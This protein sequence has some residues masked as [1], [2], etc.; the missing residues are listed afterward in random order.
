MQAIIFTDVNGS[1]GLGRAAGAY[2]IASEFRKR[3]Q[4]VKVIDFFTSFKLE[5]IKQLILRHKTKETEWIGFSSTFIAP[6]G[7]DAFA[8]RVK[9]RSALEQATSIGLT[10]E[11]SKDLFDF[12]KSLGLQT[13]V[14]GM[15][16]KHEF[17]GVKYL[18]GPAEDHF[19]K[20]FNF[21]TSQI[22]WDHDDHIFEREHLP[23]EIARG[24]IF[25]CSFCS[26][27]LNGK[28]LW[29]FCKSPKVL[30]EEMMRNYIDHGTEG[31]MF[32]DD[33]YNDSVEKI[34]KLNDMYKTLPFNLEFSSY[35]RADLI[36]SKPESWDIL[37]ESGL[38]SVFFGIES[39]NH[40]SAKSI[41]KGMHPDKVKEGLQWMKEKH[42]HILISCGFIAGLPY[43]TKESLNSTCDWLESNNYVDSYSF[44]VLSISPLSKIGIDP[45]KYGYKFNEQGWYNDNMTAAEAEKIASRSMKNTLN[46]FTFYNRLRNLNYNPEEVKRLDDSYQE[47]INSRK[48]NKIKEYKNAVLSC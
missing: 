7:F 17:N 5:E 44:Q 4:K 8:S 32:S 11:E 24:C 13:I 14:G 43:E 1:I 30:K 34:S 28:K 41:G 6:V 19:F 33:T 21:N 2:R 16:T 31:Y 22:I 47:Q 37:A 27:P 29:D 26:Y 36:I 10:Y 45:V 23:I 40:E 3:N 42:P 12:I 46:G 35:A 39:F 18:Y 9:I 20:D 38:K 25:K 15:R 48:Y